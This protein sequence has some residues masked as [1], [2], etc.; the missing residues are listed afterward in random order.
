RDRPGMRESGLAGI[1]VVKRRDAGRRESVA[2][3]FPLAIGW[4]R[5]VPAAG[6]RSARLFRRHPPRLVGRSK[7]VVVI[8]RVDL[9]DAALFPVSELVDP[10]GPHGAAA[11]AADHGERPPAPLGGSTS[12]IEVYDGL[13]V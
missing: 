9:P 2:V 12:R 3:H 7:S 6:N 1:L 5:Q 4:I 13:D 8:E 10:L 11:E